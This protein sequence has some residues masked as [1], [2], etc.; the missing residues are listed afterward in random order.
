MSIQFFSRITSLRPSSDESQLGEVDISLQA[1]TKTGMPYQPLCKV[2]DLDCWP[3][4]PDW[5]SSSR[6]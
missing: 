1:A 4:Q 6:R 2:R 5:T 3:N